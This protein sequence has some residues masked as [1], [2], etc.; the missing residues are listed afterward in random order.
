MSNYPS[1][2]SENSKKILVV[3]LIVALG[4]L[5]AARK[6]FNIDF[7]EVVSPLAHSIIEGNEKKLDHIHPLLKK[8]RFTPLGM[9]WPTYQ[10]Y[11]SE[12]FHIIS[13]V[14]YWIAVITLTF[15]IIREACFGY[16][17]SIILTMLALFV[18]NLAARE[19]FD[20][21]LIGPAPYLGYQN[22]NFRMSAVLLSL[23]SILLVFR[24]QLIL[25]GVI[26]GLTSMIHLKYGLRIFGLLVGCMVLWNLRGRH[27][28]N[29]SQ[30]RIPWRSIAG[31]SCISMGMLG[32]MYLY[33]VDSFKLFAGLDVPRVVTPFLTRLDWAIKNEP[34]DYLISYHF[35][36]NISFFGF[37]FLALATILL[38]E[39]I[40]RHT[41]NIRTKT[42]AVVLILSVF[43]AVAF[44]AF[45]FL[46][47]DFLIGFLPLSWSTPL[48]FARA[49]DLIW[50]VIVAFTIAFCLC[51]L[52]WSEN[53]DQKFQR[54]P[55][56]IR[57]LF[58]HAGF[59]GFVLLNVYIF[60]DKKDGSIFR[61][62]GQD[63]LP[64]LDISYSQIC[65]KD[66]VL[67]EKTLDR[68]WELAGR[69]DETAFYEQLETLEDIFE[70]TLKPAR[71]RETN[72][73]DTKT[74]RILHNLK[75]NRYRSA[76]KEL[77]EGRYQE[78]Y[79]PY[80]WDC[81]EKG[82]GIHPQRVEIP[83]QDFYDINSWIKHNT[84]N[85]RGII[86]P[87]Y[88]P[89]F[90]S[91]S[92]HVSFWDNKRDQHQMYLMADYYPM[93]LHRLQELAG[94]QGV[95]I[96]PG[97]RHGMVGL[98]GRAHFLSLQQEDL[99]KIRKS[100]PHYDYLVTENQALYGFPKLYANASLA[101]Y[102]ISEKKD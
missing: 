34:G 67:Y 78:K 27:W 84:P 20:L 1:K 90:T 43:I 71:I 66:T 102:G 74:L 13:V 94:A 11:Y 37:L 31:F 4:T 32:G 22:F 100:Y 101:V 79:S 45:G 98:R 25:S 85:D 21:P 6:Q 65:T 42:V 86:A 26:L 46:F 41:H 50:V 3:V 97:S 73:P 55:F 39:L 40:R 52:L 18:G 7:N 28:A 61:E 81:D 24:G 35:F 95:L 76:I 44:F 72:N 75:L 57:N 58:L 53:L 96:A 99:R 63:H 33:I 29:A 8:E 80:L 10:M 89:R 38:C 88:I 77:V 2:F 17:S 92:K 64:K 48:M 47:D 54:C 36:S 51:A 70:R 23:A 16:Y 59:A 87:P 83:F 30:L 93:G 14:I 62:I 49:W 19:L 15:L 91:Y 56:S 68:V 60:L 9:T 5:M 12:A 82:S 69:Q